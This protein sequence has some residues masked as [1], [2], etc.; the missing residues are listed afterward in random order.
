M[1][2]MNTLH[3]LVS[4]PPINIDAFKHGSGRIDSQKEAHCVYLT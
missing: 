2:N 4:P 3:A 1:C